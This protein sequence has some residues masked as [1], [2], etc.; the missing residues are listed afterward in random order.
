VTISAGFIAGS[1][2]ALVA[3]EAAHILMASVL[4]VRVK[5]VGISWRGP[6]IVRESGS[7]MVNACIALAGPGINL[8]LAFWFYSS[9]PLF[10]QINLVLGAS[11]LLPIKGLDGWRAWNALKQAVVETKPRTKPTL[12]PQPIRVATKSQAAGFRA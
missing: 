4:S 8:L 7:P 11:N 12:T 2:I 10:G 6:Y 1:F 9:D 5:R 3:H